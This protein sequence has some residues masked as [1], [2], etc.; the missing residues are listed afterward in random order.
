MA[1]AQ[2][3]EFV[4]RRNGRVHLNRRGRHFSRLL[5]A[6][7]CASAVVM[8]DTP[9]S[10]VVWRVLATHSIRQFPLHFPARATPRAITFQLD[11][12]SYEKERKLAALNGIETYW[13]CKKFV[14]FS[15]EGVRLRGRCYA[16]DKR[17]LLVRFPAWRRLFLS[18]KAPRP[19]TGTTQTSMYWVPGPFP[20]GYSDRVTS[21]LCRC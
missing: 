5:A 15:K 6:E 16:T 9:S 19:G 3:Q 20:C 2:K 12:S 18:C 8:M 7:V 17:R 13:D 21:I 4:F 11:S 1:H 14:C 10:E